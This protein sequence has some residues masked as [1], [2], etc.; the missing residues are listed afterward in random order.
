MPMKNLIL[1]PELKEIIETKNWQVLKDISEDI[2]PAEIAELITALEPDEVWELIEKLELPKRA[3]VF[4]HLDLSLQIQISEIIDRKKLAELLTELPS[5]DRVDLFKK[6]PPEKQ[7]YILPA[8]AQAEREDIRKLSSYP[9]KSAGSV[10]TSEYVS[11]LQNISVQEAINRLRLEAPKKETIYYSYIIDESRILI[12]AVSLTDLIMANP[13]SIIKDI[14][15]EEV[16]YANVDE[17][18][19][20]AARKIQKFDLL[21][22]PVVNMNHVLVGIITHDDALDIITQEQTEDFEKIMAIA[23]SHESGVYL[24]TSAF[25]HF[26]NRAVWIIGLAA[27]GLVS[28]III[29][30]FESTLT[31]LMILALYM[32]MV[33]DTGGNTGSQSATVIVRALALGEVSFKDIIKI[34]WKELRISVLL[35]LAL[36]ILSWG[37][38]MFLSRGSDI[39]NGFTLNNIG[40]TIAIALSL[41]VV[42]STLIGAILPLAASKFKFDPAIVASPALT[43]IVDI[44]GLLIYF[45]TAKLLLNL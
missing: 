39:P 1:L 43:T 36:G 17:D 15:Q 35:A 33:A 44:T 29:H 23:G 27:L 8:L 41:Q 37:K 21:A 22:I 26:K 20:T 25:T 45:T 3:E 31:G 19:E 6:F 2:H 13:N 32:P 14:M 16:I 28:G 12:G 18:Q 40:V 11:F 42:T 5:D 10:M 9:E 7:E 34:L 24:Q 38:V 30:S 4:T